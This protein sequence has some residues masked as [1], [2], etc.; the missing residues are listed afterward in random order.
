MVA[1]DGG[2]GVKLGEI[3][4]T[5]VIAFQIKKLTAAVS[6]VPQQEK[7]RADLVKELTSERA[8]IA[9]LSQEFEELQKMQETES[10]KYKSSNL[11]VKRVLSIRNPDTFQSARI[12]VMFVL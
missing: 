2:C 9:K 6:K 4:V 1:G 12:N 3:V 10:N 8:K 11:Q 5:G 7:E